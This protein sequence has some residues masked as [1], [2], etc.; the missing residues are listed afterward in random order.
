MKYLPLGT[1]SGT[2]AQ[3]RS[4]SGAALFVG[5]DKHWHL[6]DCGEGTLSQIVKAKLA[7]SNLSAI[8]VTHPHPDHCLGLPS[9]LSALSIQGRKAPLEIVAA[10]A[11]RTLVETVCSC[12]EIRL[13]FPLR[14]TA[15]ED[16]VSLGLPGGAVVEPVELAH[17]TRSFGYLFQTRKL[18]TRADLDYL[19]SVGV[20]QGPEV[21]A[22]LRGELSVSAAGFPVDPTRCA[23]A[24][25]EA[26]SCFIGGDNQDPSILARRAPGAGAW[27]HEATYLQRDWENGGAGLLWGH[28][29]ADMV[30]AAAAEGRPGALIL[31]HFSPR[32]AEPGLAGPQ[33][34]SIDDLAAEAAARFSGPVILAR[35]LVPIEISPQIL[36]PADPKP[37][38]R[39]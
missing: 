1:S 28:S 31:T 13:E 8:L 16:G 6:V 23:V 39:I 33:T 21:G 15:P 18:R 32:Y 34:P 3:G 29:S 5:S 17:R 36:P 25:E 11:V 20:S 26:E 19:A 37:K 24:F 27:V 35:D 4:V 10:P 2:P 38:P 7:L 14:W 22:A 30:G 9:I 12:A